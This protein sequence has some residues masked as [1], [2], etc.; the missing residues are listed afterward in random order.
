M[1]MSQVPS[2]MNLVNELDFT[3]GG[4]HVMH[5]HTHMSFWPQLLPKHSFLLQ[6]GGWLDGNWRDW[7]RSMAESHVP[8]F[9]NLAHEPISAL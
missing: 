4:I 5:N 3:Y 2:F 6:S 8:S 1:A 9:T 7:T